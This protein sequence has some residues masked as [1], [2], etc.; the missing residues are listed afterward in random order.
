MFCSTPCSS[1]IGA[2][3]DGVLLTGL[4]GHLCKW[5]VQEM[6]VRTLLAA[7]LQPPAADTPVLSAAC[8]S[9][10]K[11]IRLRQKLTDA[12]DSVKGLFGGKKQT[13]SQVA[14]LEAVQVLAPS[15][16]RAEQHH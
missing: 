9:A 5:H 16:A 14:K 6:L 8:C 10:G 12:A 4:T 3:F 7:C 15:F 1:G 13:E 2:A 11:I